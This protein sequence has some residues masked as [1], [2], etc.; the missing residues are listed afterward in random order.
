MKN[1]DAG[2]LPLHYS[3]KNYSPIYSAYL[4]LSLPLVIVLRV[5]PD[6]FVLQGFIRVPCARCILPVRVSTYECFSASEISMLKSM[7]YLIIFPLLF[8]QCFSGL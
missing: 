1:G 3:L 8:E 2:I 6:I 4:V 7:F 5:F